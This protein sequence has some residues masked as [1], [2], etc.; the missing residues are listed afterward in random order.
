M[1]VAGDKKIN[2]RGTKKGRVSQDR[3]VFRGFVNVDLTKEQK[4]AFSVWYDDNLMWDALHKLVMEGYRFSAKYEEKNDSV[5]CYLQTDNPDSD[6]IG[7]VLSMR[8]EFTHK[9]VARTVYVATQILP[10]VWDAPKKRF[11]DGDDW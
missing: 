9:A 6:N 10:P 5:A 1:S 4:K 11:D 8:A 3:N 7:L 2:E